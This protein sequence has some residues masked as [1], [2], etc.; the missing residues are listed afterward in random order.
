MGGAEQV[1]FRDYSIGGIGATTLGYSFDFVNDRVISAIKNG[2]ATSINSQLELEASQKLIDVIP[3]VDSLRFTRSGGEATTLAVRLARA[4]SGKNTVLF[5]GYHGWHDWYL[6]A[7]FKHKLGNHLLPEIP[8]A[9]VPEELADTSHPL[10]MV[11]AVIFS[12]IH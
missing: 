12:L 3:W 1:I 2:S 7:A 10:S 6:S 4:F 8:I 9:G 11:I 5:S